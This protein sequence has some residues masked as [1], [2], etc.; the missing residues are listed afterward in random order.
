LRQIKKNA[1]LAR[2]ASRIAQLEHV[3]GKTREYSRQR[4]GSQQSM[5][6]GESRS[7]SSKFQLVVNTI[8]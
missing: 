7:F 1:Q 4:N 3:T 6:L 2:H 5:E 8:G